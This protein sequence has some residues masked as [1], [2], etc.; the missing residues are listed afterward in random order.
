MAGKAFPAFPA[1]AQPAVLRIWQEAHGSNDRYKLCKVIVNG[2]EKWW[3]FLPVTWSQNALQLTHDSVHNL[4]ILYCDVTVNKMAS[5]ITNNSTIYLTVF[6]CASK[7]T[8]KLHMNGPCERNPPVN[9]GFPSVTRKMF[10]FD[11]VIMLYLNQEFTQSA[12]I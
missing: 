6:R 1:H 5:Q 10:P 2:F 3:K 8:S 7:K 9:G 11:C 12:A 4:L